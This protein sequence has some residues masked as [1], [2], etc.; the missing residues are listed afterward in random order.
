[1]RVVPTILFMENISF[2]LKI[3]SAHFMGNCSLRLSEVLKDLKWQVGVESARFH[4]IV[5]GESLI[6]VFCCLLCIFYCRAT[7]ILKH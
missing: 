7:P 1:M 5:N 4:G 2:S 3:F 6:N